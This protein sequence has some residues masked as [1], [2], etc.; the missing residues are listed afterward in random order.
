M[1]LLTKE[2]INIH[3]DATSSYIW[4]KESLKILLK[5]KII[6]KLEIV[7]IMLVNIEVQHIVFVI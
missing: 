3:Q 6:R 2:E 1:L 4:G 5:V 7:F